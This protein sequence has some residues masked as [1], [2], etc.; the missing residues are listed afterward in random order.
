MRP[1]NGRCRMTRDE[2][3]VRRRELDQDPFHKSLTN[4]TKKRWREKNAERLNADRRMKY[5]ENRERELERGRAWRKANPE[6]AKASWKKWASK[7]R[8]R[9]RTRDR[10]RYNDAEKRDRSRELRKAREKRPEVRARVNAL[11]R[12]YYRRKKNTEAGIAWKVKY[13]LEPRW[14]TLITETPEAIERYE[15]RCTVQTWSLFVKWARGM[16]MTFDPQKRGRK[17][18]R[19]K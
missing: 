9:L 7:N 13:L 15:R 10:E 17:G 2:R 11:K 6:K 14:K 8:A 4:R 12:L 16:G 1:L 5:A 19:R 18:R 3:N